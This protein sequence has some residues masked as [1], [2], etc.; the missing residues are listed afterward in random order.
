MSRATEERRKY[1]QARSRCRYGN[2]AR[3]DG[4]YIAD[5]QYGHHYH[6]RHNAAH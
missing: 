1:R 3:H 4:Q 5:E 6:K 2:H